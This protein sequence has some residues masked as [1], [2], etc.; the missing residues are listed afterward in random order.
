MSIDLH[1]TLTNFIRTPDFDTYDEYW[2]YLEK[3]IFIESIEIIEQILCK[4][5][6]ESEF[7]QLY[8]LDKSVYNEKYNYCI[9]K[10]HIGTC[11]GCIKNDI[12]VLDELKDEISNNVCK[13]RLYNTYE[14]AS[15]EYTN[16]VNEM[17][18]NKM[19][20]IKHS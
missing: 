9:V 8:K 2:K 13:A 17:G 10:S 11:S 6:G 18:V 4:D 1:T 7:V 14:E 12:G 19:W 16:I 20:K 3:G 15:K 5:Y